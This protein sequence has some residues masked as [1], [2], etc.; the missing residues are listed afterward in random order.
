MEK[1]TCNN[2]NIEIFD[3]EKMKITGVLSVDT[4]DEKE[5]VL[6]TELGTMI[7]KGQELD[8]KKLD[9]DNGKVN[10]NGT[11]CSITYTN[12][13]KAKNKNESFINRILK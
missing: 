7:V 1:T 9:I 5:V 6:D 8:I 4:F 13:S 3:R 2:H 12:K 11:I 10:I